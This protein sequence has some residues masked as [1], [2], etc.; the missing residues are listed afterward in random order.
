MTHCKRERDNIGEELSSQA[1]Q[2]N[3]MHR[4]KHITRGWH[5]YIPCTTIYPGHGGYFGCLKKLPFCKQGSLPHSSPTLMGLEK[6]NQPDWQR[7]VGE[8]YL[9]NESNFQQREHHHSPADFIQCELKM[10]G[11]FSRRLATEGLGHH[12]ARRDVV[13]HSRQS[14]RSEAG[15][16]FTC[17]CT[18]TCNSISTGA[19]WSRCS[20]W[21]SFSSISVVANVDDQVGR[22]DLGAL[23]LLQHPLTDEGTLLIITHWSHIVTMR[24]GPTSCVKCHFHWRQVKDLPCLSGWVFQDECIPYSTHLPQPLFQRQLK[25]AGRPP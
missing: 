5:T 4:T 24:T 6:A 11:K 9:Q 15:T 16:W 18:C 1:V 7:E 13:K 20:R 25:P 8:E 2:T 23:A 10:Q 12:G 19:S 17:V 14:F 22:G 21:E 3:W